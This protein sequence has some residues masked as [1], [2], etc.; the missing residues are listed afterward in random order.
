MPRRK[1]RLG[2]FIEAP[3]SVNVTLSEDHLN[4]SGRFVGKVSERT[5]TVRNIIAD[6]EKKGKCFLSKDML[7][8][9]AQVL[10]EAYLERIKDGFAVNV[11]GL[12]RLYHALDGTFG[13]PFDGPSQRPG[14]VPR[15]TPS[16]T[17]TELCGKIVCRNVLESDTSP[18]IRTVGSFPAG[19]NGAVFA[20]KLLTIT[21][22]NLK[23]AGEGAGVFFIPREKTAQSVRI[24]PEMIGD[25]FPKSLQFCLPTGMTPGVYDVE[26]RTKW[27]RSGR[28]KKELCRGERAEVTVAAEQSV[29]PL[30]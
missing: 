25:N 14:I 15:F 9:A 19:E 26:I 28:L 27:S 8:Y 17:V 11:L 30:P 16:K 20:G 12:G 3:R 22:K 24:P 29:T 21:G 23:V 5:A 1:P 6:I 10:E 18:R 4:G 2:E 13:S 7:F